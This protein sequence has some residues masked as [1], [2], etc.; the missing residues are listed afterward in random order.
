VIEDIGTEF[1]PDYPDGTAYADPPWD[2]ASS[3]SRD[4]ESVQSGMVGVVKQLVDYTLTE[5]STGKRAALDIERVVIVT[6]LALITKANK[7]PDTAPRPMPGG[8][9]KPP[10]AGAGNPRFHLGTGVAKRQEAPVTGRYRDHAASERTLL[11]WIRTAIT[12]MAFGFLV[13]KFDLFLEVATRSTAERPPP[14]SNQ[15]VGDVAGL[16]LLLLGGAMMVIA[17]V[18]F[19]RTT[20][21]IDSA[22][23]RPATGRRMDSA[24][25]LL[26]LGL[27]GTLFAYLFYTVFRR[28]W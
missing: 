16:L 10:E 9:P 18:R 7:P 19:G 24:L 1:L 13:E 17:T 2:D 6:N 26:L 21:D 4:F 20:R 15:L 23:V 5:L 27:G 28:M 22:E 14:A 25:I 8:G 12:V 3:Q 11:A